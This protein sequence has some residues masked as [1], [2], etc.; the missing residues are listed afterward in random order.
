MESPPPPKKKGWTFCPYSKYQTPKISGKEGKNDQKSKEILEK[1]GKKTRKSKKTTRKGRTG[2]QI[3]A[4]NC[5]L[6]WDLV[7]RFAANR[8]S[9]RRKT[10]FFCESTFQKM[11][12][13]E[14]WTRM[15]ELECESER[16]R[17]SCESGQVLQK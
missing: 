16:R 12:S 9:L 8:F 10:F 15:R 7:G 1:K 4:V 3:Y 6:F 13:S 11:D 14:G 5:R 17:D 2:A